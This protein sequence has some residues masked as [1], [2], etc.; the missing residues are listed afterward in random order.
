MTDHL[1]DVAFAEAVAGDELDGDVAEHLEGCIRCRRQLAAI[2]GWI[3]GQQDQMEQDAPD[4]AVQRQRVMA[5][6]GGVDGARPRSRWLRPALAAAALVAVAVGIGVLQQRAD[7][8][9][10]ELPVE[11]ILAETEALLADDSIPGFEVIDPGVDG[12]QQD[13]ADGVS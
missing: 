2:R 3:A 4:W 11:E 9:R 10:R 6:L 13:P 12:L 5:R 7:D 8:P 1:D